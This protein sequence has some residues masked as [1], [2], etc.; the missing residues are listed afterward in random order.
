[1]LDE[2][3]KVTPKPTMLR[4]TATRSQMEMLPQYYAGSTIPRVPLTGRV[5]PPV[6]NGLELGAVEPPSSFT[7]GSSPIIP[8]E[9]Y[10]IAGPSPDINLDHEGGV[11][12]L[13]QDLKEA[14][15]KSK[16]GSSSSS[17]STTNS[18]PIKFLKHVQLPL[19]AGLG[20]PE[21][22]KPEPLWTR[23]NGVPV[24]KPWIKFEEEGS[25]SQ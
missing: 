9:P 3:Q 17:S 1:M 25:K 13:F 15:T 8:G 7:V 16:S 2:Y 23:Y 10:S 22:G 24:K 18:E 5:V 4:S 12:K 21:S 14:A 6:R 11:K 20:K 19:T